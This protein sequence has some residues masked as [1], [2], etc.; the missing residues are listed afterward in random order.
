MSNLM[1][2]IWFAP[3]V[4]LPDLSDRA[5]ADVMAETP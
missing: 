1:D 4:G 3:E 2:G 5:A